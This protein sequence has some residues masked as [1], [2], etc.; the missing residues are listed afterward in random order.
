MAKKKIKKVEPQR[1]LAG[2]LGIC[3]VLFVIIWIVF[4][5][6]TGFSF[7]NYDDGL[8]VYGNPEVT[9]GLSLHGIGWAFTHVHG[10]NWHPLTSISHLFDCQFYGLNPGAHHFTNDLLHSIAVV[11][12]FLALQQMTGARWRSA[13]VA[14]LF[15]IHPLRAESV[16]WI[17]ERKDVLSGVFFMLTL[18]AYVRYV[19]KPLFGNYCFVFVIFA[20]GLMSKP[21]LVTLPFILLLL[22]YWPLGRL[23]NKQG[24]QQLVVEKIP[25]LVLSAASCMATLLAQKG[26]M[27]S[28]QQ[29]Q[30]APRIYNAFISCVV[31]LGQMFWPFRLGLFYPYAEHGLLAKGVLSAALLILISAIVFVLRKTHPYLITGWL[32]YL[33]MLVPVIGIIQVGL[34]AHADRYTYLS[35][36]GLSVALV[37]GV[38]DVSRSWRHRPKS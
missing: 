35:Q 23:K 7:I 30:L 24:I 28:T 17:A 25:L 36:I 16:A 38:T 22:D 15:A 9:K 19:K 37:W 11:L 32:W 13:F 31:Y 33:G 27:A 12:L 26:A 6:A 29:L 21:M 20:L 3:L 2:T 14:A 5:Q 4:G 18:M 34:Q 1:Q 8:Y 10:G